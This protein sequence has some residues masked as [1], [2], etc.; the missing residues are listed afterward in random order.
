MPIFG[1]TYCDNNS[2]IFGPI[3]LKILWELRRLLL[4]HYIIYII[5]YRLVMRNPSYDADF[6]FLVFWATFAGK[7]A[8][9]PHVLLI[10]WDI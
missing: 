4:S 8:S 1:H 9:L 3:G 7:W 6:S 10:V 2:A 5:I